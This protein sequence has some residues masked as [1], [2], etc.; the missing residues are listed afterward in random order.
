[1]D[2]ICVKGKIVEDNVQKNIPRM[3][4]S[5]VMDS[6]TFDIQSLLSNLNLGNVSVNK[7]NSLLNV[8]NT[9][10]LGEKKIE[11]VKS[12]THE[13]MNEIKIYIDF[14]FDQLQKYMDNKIEEKFQ[15]LNKI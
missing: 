10:S 13:Q 8:G 12:L 5:P 14:K 11:E 2:C 15:H 3:N 4:N 7:M 6:S 1:L 9:P